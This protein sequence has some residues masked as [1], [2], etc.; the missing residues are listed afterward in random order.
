MKPSIRFLPTL[1]IHMEMSVSDFVDFWARQHSYRDDPKY[2]ANIDLPQLTKENLLQL[3][4]WKNGMV[5]SAAKRK[6]MED[7]V[8]KHVA[9]INTLKKNAIF[10]EPLFH[11]TFPDL[12]TVWRIFLRHVIQPTQFPDFDY[13]AYHAYR[14]IAGLRIKEIAKNA[15]I[16]ESFYLEKYLPFYEELMRYSTRPNRRRLDDALAAFGQFI[17]ENPKMLNSQ[18]MRTWI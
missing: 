14:F 13:H 16:K 18:R 10:D 8:L 15:F 5:L 6:T 2:V 3:L 9:V 4:E 1:R 11:K 7:K 12:G 17:G